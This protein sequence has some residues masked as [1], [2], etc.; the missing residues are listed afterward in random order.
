MV[1]I[2]EKKSTSYYLFIFI[3]IMTL[4]VI[5]AGSNILIVKAEYIID[6]GCAIRIV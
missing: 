2:K 3:L 4:F 1:D 6:A 5:D